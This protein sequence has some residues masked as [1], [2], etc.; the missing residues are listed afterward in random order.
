MD[1]CMFSDVRAG[2]RGR[3]GIEK[4]RKNVDKQSRVGNP[5]GGGVG[6]WEAA[7]PPRTDH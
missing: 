7:A 1:R 4:A 2:G 6:I 3:G 5:F